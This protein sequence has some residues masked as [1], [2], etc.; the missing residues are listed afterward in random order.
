[1]Q[2]LAKRGGGLDRKTADPYLTSGTVF[3]PLEKTHH[4]KKDR[5]RHDI[6]KRGKINWRRHND[7]P[8]P[9]GAG[10]GVKRWIGKIEEGR[11]DSLS[12]ARGNRGKSGTKR[13]GEGCCL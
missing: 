7:A 3:N 8:C 9:H 13:A 5:G 10:R 6:K 1:M 2:E 11:W 12:T 4:N